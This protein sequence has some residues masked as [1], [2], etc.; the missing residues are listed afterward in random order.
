MNPLAPTTDKHSRA[1]G[2]QAKIRQNAVHFDMNSEWWPSLQEE[3][4][5]FPRSAHDDQ[6][7]ALAWIG[8]TVDDMGRGYTKQELEEQ[9]YDEMLEDYQ[10]AS[11]GTGY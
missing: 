8:L 3:L 1:R 7:D 4:T 11:D 10:F 6:V 2:I 9:E 5:R